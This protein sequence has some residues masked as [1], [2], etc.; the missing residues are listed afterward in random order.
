LRSLRLG[1]IILILLPMLLVMIAAAQQP[2]HDPRPATDVIGP[3]SH[4]I[5]PPAAWML[6]EEKYTYDVDW[7]I[8]SAGKITLSLANDGVQQSVVGTAESV[9]VVSLL[10]PVHDRFQSVYDPKTFCS[11]SLR[12]HTEEGFHKRDTLINYNYARRK[13]VLDETNLKNNQAKHEENEIPGC[14]TDVLS[15]LMYLRSLPLIPGGTYTFPLN[16]GGKTVDVTAKVES[17]ETIK[18][19]A[20]TFQTIRVSPESTAGPLKN[21]GRIWIWYTDDARR[22]PVQMRGKMFWGTLTL[23]LE[24]IEASKK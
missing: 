4:I 23:K 14:V 21:K 9:G 16:D 13:S 10:Y 6:P 15:G 22:I 18:V 7:R 1:N 24:K 11:V 19:P 12:K 20:G 17:R 2:A 8:W 5:P 3:L